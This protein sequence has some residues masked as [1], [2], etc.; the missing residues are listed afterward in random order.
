MGNFHYRLESAPAFATFNHGSPQQLPFRCYFITG[1]PKNLSAKASIAGS[2]G[3]RKLLG[4]GY[5]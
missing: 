2:C 3:A 1:Q 5:S 4:V